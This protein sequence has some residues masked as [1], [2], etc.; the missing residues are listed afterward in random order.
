M[1]ELYTWIW[2]KDGKRRHAPEKHDDLLMALQH[3]VYYIYYVIRRSDKNR[4]VFNNV[5]EV[6]RDGV[7]YTVRDEN[8]KEND[9]PFAKG[10]NSFVP[11][12]Y[13]KYRQQSIN[14]DNETGETF[15]RGR[16]QFL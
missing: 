3:G 16:S 4:N 5:F 1:T 6:K 13:G 14:I 2:D 7:S 11:N 12:K 9:I 10:K 8:K 15:W